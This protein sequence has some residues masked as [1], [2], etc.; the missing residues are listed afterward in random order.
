[1][2]LRAGTSGFSYREWRGSFYPE[3]F[4]ASQMLRFYAERFRGVEINNTFYR[5]PSETVL[6]DWRAQAPPG[7]TFALKASQS[8]THRKRLKDV[9]EAAAYFFSNA[10]ALGDKL[11]P[12]L[13]Q[14]PP[15]FKKDLPRVVEFL[16]LV[17][18]GVRIAFEF[19]HPSWFDDEVYSAL[20]AHDAALCTAHAE[21]QETP[22]MATTFWGYLRL[23]NV[24]YA[25]AELD[26][27]IERIRVQPW[28]E[29]Y[30]FFKHEDEATG[31]RLAARFQ[32]RFER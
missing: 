13:V 24:S 17:P 14:L 20:R 30:V 25:D 26:V 8:L 32:E 5:M 31:P 2:L 29:A 12:V 1:M 18:N 9:A 28:Q 21:D 19:R 10:S 3:R 4:P 15:N 11:G 23:R 7:F 6:A 16:G 22:L 27:W